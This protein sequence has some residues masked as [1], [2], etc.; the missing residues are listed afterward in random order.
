MKRQD[1]EKDPSSAPQSRAA[2]P[3][4]EVPRASFDPPIENPAVVA[5]LKG[6]AP[7]VTPEPMQVSVTDGEIS[8]SFAAGPRALAAAKDAPT[9]DGPNVVV[10]LKANPPKQADPAKL[11]T[12]FR[13]RARQK[14]FTVPLAILVVLV[15]AAIASWLGRTTASGPPTTRPQTS[16]APVVSASVPPWQSVPAP[17][18]PTATA[19]PFPS[20]TATESSPA[21]TA[22]PRSAPT[23]KPGRTPKGSDEL[24]TVL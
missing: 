2:P 18:V 21:P 23:T 20:D 4:E 6:L 14:S 13:I 8:A 10:D 22:P 3:G 15:G 9:L 24:P 12:T 17:P 1:L 19:A 11:D 16:A 7:S 5:L